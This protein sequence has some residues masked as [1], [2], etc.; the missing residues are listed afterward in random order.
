VARRA[1][2]DRLPVLAR[3]AAWLVYA[4]ARAAEVAVLALPPEAADRLAR[5][6]GRALFRFD[7]E[8]R[9]TAVENLRVAFGDGL[10]PAARESTARRSF[11]SAFLVG[12]D[13]VRR[14]RVLRSVRD[15]RRR[16]RYAPGMWRLLEA[17]ARGESGV[18]LAGHAG[19]WELLASCALAER[20]PMSFVAR[21]FGNPYLDRHVAAT[22]G[23]PDAVLS[24]EGAARGLRRALERGRWGG[25]V[26]DQNA[27]MHGVY[28]DFF[29]VPA[30]T[31]PF[32]A[33]LAVRARRPVW[34]AAAMRAGPRFAYDLTVVRHDVVPTGDHDEDVLRCLRAFHAF[35]E[36]LVR[37]HPDQ[38]FWMHRRWRTRPPGEAPAPHLPRY[39]R[40]GTDRPPW[41]R[42]ASP[43]AAAPPRPRQAARG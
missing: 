15:F 21:P 16:I 41:R 33:S 13:A 37:R 27:G 25:V 30:S 12:L 34:F 31:Y 5:C 29:G 11:E 35:L 32:A 20:V 36:G 17:A 28:V 24:K 6:A 3:A 2:T 43:D 8:R 10:S 26:S 42:L 14:P 39:P 18:V 40:R 22:R 4:A 19:N 7:R 9:A 38:Y 1:A 23:G